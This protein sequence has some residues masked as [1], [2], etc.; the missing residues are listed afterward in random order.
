MVQVSITEMYDMS[1]V[2]DKL[3]II[4][5]HSPTMQSIA[6][7]WHGLLDNHKFVRLVKC[8][9]SVACASVM[10]ADPLQVG[11]DA[12][13]IA[14]Q[15]MMNPILY[16][17]CTNESWNTILNRLYASS[18]L[19]EA[20]SIRFAADAFPS[21]GAGGQERL[22][23]NVLAEGGWRKAMP[24]VGFNIN[25]LRPLVFP[26][27]NTYGN[28]MV[29]DKQSAS[30]LNTPQGMESDAY[31]QPATPATSACTTFR[32]SAQPMPRV[33]CHQPGSNLDSEHPDPWPS[34]TLS[35]IPKTYVACI[36]TPPN[37]SG[38]VMY[39][40]M[41]VRWTVEFS[42]LVTVLEKESALDIASLGYSLVYTRT[43]SDGSK[44]DEVAGEDDKVTDTNSVDTMNT[45]VNL[46]LEK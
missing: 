3:G 13:Q 9:V 38:N 42:D 11:L 33:P 29:Q 34:F 45:N 10:P 5:I 41:V 8:D 21:M 46:V 44:L 23:Y 20:N 31:G 43:Y 7:R 27:L 19:T 6:R 22:Y 24:Q 40:R 39:Y 30:V 26:V 35:N 17:A 2:K 36:L 37:K 12:D 32:G 25:G 28:T 4:G 1:T 15:D 18:G 16:R 14:P